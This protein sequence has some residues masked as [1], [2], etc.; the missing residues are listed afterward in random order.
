MLP[1]TS[2][3]RVLWIGFALTAAVCEEIVYRGYLLSQFRAVTGSTL[4]AVVL[5]AAAYGAAHLALPI[6]MVASVGMLGLLLG[7]IAAWQKSLVS[8]M[9]LHAGTGLMAIAASQ[10]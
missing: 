2:Q 6:E 4:A 10:P 9:I 8:A 7:L 5:Q 1:H 3:E